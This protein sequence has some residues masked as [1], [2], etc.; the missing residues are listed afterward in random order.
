MVQQEPGAK[1][2][3]W[4]LG[5]QNQ[6]VWAHGLASPPFYPRAHPHQAMSCWDDHAG[7]PWS[8]W[9][10]PST[11]G[12]RCLCGPVPPVPRLLFED[13]THKDF[14]SVWDSEDE[15]E[16]LSRTLLLVAKVRPGAPQAGPC[17]GRRT[18]VLR[19]QGL[20]WMGRDMSGQHIG[21]PWP[22]CLWSVGTP[23]SVP[24]A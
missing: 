9:V 6:Q 5:S 22:L 10:G 17:L 16:E 15:I 24:V 4:G 21:E 20:G 23:T 12:S 14:Q 7:C 3:V 1:S 11:G 18:A 19:P 8:L 2:R 13:W